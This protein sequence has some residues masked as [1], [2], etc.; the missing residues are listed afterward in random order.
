MKGQVNNPV[1]MG[2][3]HEHL[4]KIELNVSSA[5]AHAFRL[6][7]WSKKHNYIFASIDGNH[8]LKIKIQ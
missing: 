3:C 2:L 4:T 1:L 5:T 8:F 7:F 6:S